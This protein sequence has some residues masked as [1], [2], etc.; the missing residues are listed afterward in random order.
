MVTVSVKRL[1]AAIEEAEA[2]NPPEMSEGTRYLYERL[3]QKLVKEADARLSEIDFNRFGLD[4]IDSIRE[5]YNDTLEYNEMEAERIRN[6][7]WDAPPI[8]ASVSYV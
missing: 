5:I 2:F 7:I 1:I 8:M 4:D 3:Y 6:R